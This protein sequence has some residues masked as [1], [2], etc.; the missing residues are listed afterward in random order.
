MARVVVYCI[1]YST[2]HFS[3]GGWSEASHQLLLERQTI[4]TG[5]V[6]GESAAVASPPKL[7]PLTAV[8]AVET[9]SRVQ[10]GRCACLSGSRSVTHCISHEGDLD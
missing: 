8:A 5:H 1:Q 7:E 6:A 9:S 2:A 3:A 10:S 4:G